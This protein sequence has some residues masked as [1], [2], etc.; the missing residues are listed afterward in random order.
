SAKQELERD[1]RLYQ[2]KSLA[3]QDLEAQIATVGQY[4]GAVKADQAQIQSALLNLDYTRITSPI[5]GY[6]GLRLVD[7]GN[8]VQAGDN[9]G[10]VT[11]TQTDPIAVTFSL[12]QADL[13]AV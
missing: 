10:I 2:Q 9:T 12:P 8:L 4:T 6:T 11:I 1:R 3:R 5:S 13:D 7:A